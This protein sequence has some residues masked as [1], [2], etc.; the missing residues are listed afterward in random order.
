MNLE[1]VMRVYDREGLD[2]ALHFGCKPQ[3]IAVHLTKT[4]KYHFEVKEGSRVRC[5]WPF[6]RTGQIRPNLLADSHKSLG[7]KDK[8]GKSDLKKWAASEEFHRKFAAKLPKH[9]AMKALVAFFEKGPYLWDKPKYEGA[10]LDYVF[11]YGGGPICEIPELYEVIR[12]TLREEFHYSA[13]PSRFDDDPCIL[14]CHMKLFLKGMSNAQTLLSYEK[15]VT[16][17]GVSKKDRMLQAGLSYQG[18][19]RLMGGLEWLHRN[20][21]L[22]FNSV[23]SGDNVVLLGWTETP[24]RIEQVVKDI[25][26]G[27]PKGT[28]LRDFRER[29]RQALDEDSALFE[30]E[31][32][33]H[34][35]M[36]GTGSRIAVRGSFELTVAE[37]AK[38]MVTFLDDFSIER[39]GVSYRLMP[40]V[41]AIFGRMPKRCKLTTHR[42]DSFYRALLLGTPYPEFIQAIAKEGILA[43][44]ETKDQD[45]FPEAAFHAFCRR[46]MQQNKEEYMSTDKDQPCYI[47]GRIFGAM[48]HRAAAARDKGDQKNSITKSLGRVMKNPRSLV[49]EAK[50][51]EHHRAKLIKRKQHSWDTLL[52]PL[53]EELDNSIEKTGEV[54]PSVANSK[55]Q[56]QFLRGRHH[57]LSAFERVWRERNKKKTDKEDEGGEG[58]EGAVSAE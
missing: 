24:H 42:V 52:T 4:G 12:D 11:Y 33:Y 56:M 35:L 15:S 13:A 5:P 7:G 55:Q 18:H 48:E 32:P 44:A 31:T 8:D 37:V 45:S 26:Q 40:P 41:Y 46:N 16:W 57:E 29:I 51:S 53:F 38:R 34:F 22:P 1:T 47:A 19:R 10:A 3:H 14:D 21:A 30:D 17:N 50:R 58:D 39:G 23:S 6:S 27:C 28:P 2:E 49:R 36:F 43:L 9:P 54:L 25:L 20:R